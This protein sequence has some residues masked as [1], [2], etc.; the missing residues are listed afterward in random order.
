[1]FLIIG[2]FFCFG[3]DAVPADKSIRPKRQKVVKDHYPN[4][5]QSLQSVNP[6]N[7]VFRYH[8]FFSNQAKNTTLYK[9]AAQELSRR[10]AV[11]GALADTASVASD[12]SIRTENRT[13]NPWRYRP[14]SGVLRIFSMVPP[15]A[16]RVQP[17]QAARFL[18]PL[19][20][21]IT[22]YTYNPCYYTIIEIETES[23]LCTKT[24]VPDSGRYYCERVHSVFSFLSAVGRLHSSG[25][26][27]GQLP[28]D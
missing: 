16:S 6:I 8:A 2:C 5:A 27:G 19:S 15:G 4:R 13:V 7:P 20:D 9:N 12:V 26:V 10:A 17:I 18:T 25:G 14:A 21:V 11:S 28:A 22:E 23:G 3:R 24:T 1:M